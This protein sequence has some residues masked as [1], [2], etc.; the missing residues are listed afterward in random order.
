MTGTSES[1]PVGQ[2]QSV[3]VQEKSNLGTRRDVSVPEDEGFFQLFLL[4]WL[5]CWD[6]PYVLLLLSTNIWQNLS[7]H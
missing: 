1:Q 7:T 6:L 3:P 4:S 5:L 2:T